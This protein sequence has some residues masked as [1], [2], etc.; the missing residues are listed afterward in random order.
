[1]GDRLY[2]ATPFQDNDAVKALGARFS[3]KPRKGWW[4]RLDSDWRPFVRWLPELSADPNPGGSRPVG[5]SARAATARSATRPVPKGY[6]GQVAQ[7]YLHL[8]GLADPSSMTAG[9]TA[10]ERVTWDELDAGR[11]APERQDFTAFWQAVKKKQ[12]AAPA[13]LEPEDAANAAPTVA[14]LVAYGW[15]NQDPKKNR[16]LLA[17]PAL[18]SEGG[19]LSVVST[20]LPAFNDAY[21]EPQDTLRK[22]SLGDRARLETAMRKLPWP[23]TG[24]WADAWDLV[25]S[26]V[27]AQRPKAPH[28]L[29]D[30]HDGSDK[31]VSIWLV[32]YERNDKSKHLK[33]LYAQLVATGE[34]QAPLFAAICDS[35]PA[36][37]PLDASECRAHRRSHT[38]H[39]GGDFGLDPSQR[40][41]LLHLLATRAGK[42]LAVSGP[43]GTGKTACLQGV[44]AT[45][46]VNA[47][48][49]GAHPKAPIILATSATNQAVTN[50]ISA[51][52]DI[53]EQGPEPSL[54]SR[55]LSPVRSYGWFFAS[56][57]AARKPINK[58]FQL[59]GRHYSKWSHAGAAGGLKTVLG[60]EGGLE[61]LKGEYLRAIRSVFPQVRVR[62]VQGAVDYLLG[63]LRTLASVDC[64]QGLRG[65]AGVLAA[66]DRI[67]EL[68]RQA[69][70]ADRRRH[71]ARIARRAAREARLKAHAEESTARLNGLEARTEELAALATRVRAGGAKSGLGSWFGGGLRRDREMLLRRLEPHVGLSSL[72]DTDDG[73]LSCCEALLAAWRQA[74]EAERERLTR[75]EG[76]LD[77][78]RQ[79][80]WLAEATEL[81]AGTA[82]LEG[83][84]YELRDIGLAYLPSDVA[85]RWAA[86][87]DEGIT[88]PDAV[89]S[90]TR[91]GERLG[92]L[93]AI[94]GPDASGALEVLL[95][96]LVDRTV[97]RRCFNLAARY[98]EG[99]WLLATL[100]AEG[101]EEDPESALRRQCMLA[102]V[103]V[104][105]VYTLPNVMRDA[106]GNFRLSTADL[107]IVD[108]AGQ[109][110]PDVSVALFGLAR[111]AIVVGDVEQLKPIWNVGPS[112]D[113][114]VLRRLGLQEHTRRL[115]ER[116][117]RA[118]SGSVMQVA[119][120]ASAFRGVT[121]VRH[122]RCRPTIIEFCNLLVYDRSTPLLPMT[123]EDPER[124]FHVLRGL[125][126]GA[127]RPAGK[128][129]E[130]V[131]SPGVGGLAR[132]Q[133][134]ADRSLLQQW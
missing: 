4:I 100:A 11:L 49:D 108:E 103:I 74:G 116:G 71:G 14:V 25:Q 57:H 85:E 81:D 6:P 123:H 118:S 17:I 61:T 104:G 126:Q 92:R 107:L 80:Q 26:V 67:I 19:E 133:P 78:V 70:L 88:R 20:A 75:V 35:E 127:R 42:P 111:R 30:L 122:Y 121:L 27:A 12:D 117:L 8:A 109:A 44:I 106:D 2:L 86:D 82:E 69:G 129:A 105:T 7:Y 1:M 72:P 119:E 5:S 89:C 48:L 60:Q 38:G 22:P 54:A 131:R 23:E 95:E 130:R 76:L 56:G 134:V 99:R 90:S 39:M 40:E 64:G 120:A 43:P 37:D 66:N 73:L 10:F 53:A 68:V 41:G 47:T 114:A 58:R 96:Q 34:R 63:E 115:A 32:P 24:S 83:V 50:I 91:D 79:P 65:L 29:R 125:R 28:A 132:R 46:L 97:R 21:A 3:W 59:L 93:L 9:E 124:L 98:W 51:F 102:P 55:W 45:T 15:R 62:S 87:F 94:G 112:Q 36:A 52:G 110:S 113:T 77:A 16:A 101:A 13:P 18:V 128:R 31:P 84:L 33:A